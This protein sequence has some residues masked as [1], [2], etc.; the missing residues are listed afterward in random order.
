MCFNV[1]V[2]VLLYCSVCC[3]VAEK[4]VCRRRKESLPEN[5]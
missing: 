4:K 1:L 3:V 5:S 2:M